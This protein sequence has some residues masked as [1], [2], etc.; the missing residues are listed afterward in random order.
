MLDVVLA[1]VM[2]LSG[3]AEW[4]EDAER[5][6]VV[7]GTTAARS[8]AVELHTGGLVVREGEAG[9][10]FGSVRLGKGKRQPAY[11]LILKH[12]LGGEGKSDFDDSA[13]AEAGAAEA[14]QAI[15]I[16][17]KTVRLA[18]KIEV[19][20]KTLKVSR[21]GLTLNGKAIDLS[22]GRVFL[23]DLEGKTPHW[24]QRKVDLPAEVD[25]GTSKKAATA[26][27]RKLLGHARAKDE[28]VKKFAE[29]AAGK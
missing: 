20:E 26:L 8:D 23:V 4:C 27:G 13:S 22:R 7:Q 12:R 21:E 11:L 5:M 6:E 24:E 18:Y 15:T 19:D 2:V 28:R 1:L 3:R 29:S 17:G 10:A 9:V 16:D 25:A 14:R